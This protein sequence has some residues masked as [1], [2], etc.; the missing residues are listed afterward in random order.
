MVIGIL[1]ILYYLIFLGNIK[2]LYR[3]KLMM[4]R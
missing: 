2:F 4:K 3:Y 1:G